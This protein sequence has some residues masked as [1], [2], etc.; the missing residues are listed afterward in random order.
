[1][2]LH[3]L[4]SAHAGSGQGMPWLKRNGSFSHRG[5]RLTAERYFGFTRNDEVSKDSGIEGEPSIWRAREGGK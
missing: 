3:V 2:T 1:V 4:C 5:A